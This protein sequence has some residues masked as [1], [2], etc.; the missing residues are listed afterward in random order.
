MIIDL[1]NLKGV[2]DKTIFSNIPRTIYRV[3]FMEILINNFIKQ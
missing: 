2:F 1:S 3:T